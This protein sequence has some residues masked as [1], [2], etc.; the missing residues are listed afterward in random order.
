MFFIKQLH[1]WNICILLLIILS[2]LLK[3]TLF[4]FNTWHCL[5]CTPYV[6]SRDEKYSLLFKNFAYSSFPCS[7]LI[8]PKEPETSKRKHQLVFRRNRIC[9]PSLS[10]PTSS[11]PLPHYLSWCWFLG[12][13]V[14]DG[15]SYT[16]TQTYSQCSITLNLPAASTD[17][18][19]LGGRILS[20]M[21][22][23]RHT[24]LSW[25]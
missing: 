13:L 4:C 6:P 14:V 9:A 22:I 11:S 20:S 1:S 25:L 23:C 15:S 17:N 3:H 18:P 7:N 21:S 5:S 2:L 16:W 12:P 19:V 10:F 24:G 8:R